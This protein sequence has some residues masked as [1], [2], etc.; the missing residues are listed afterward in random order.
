MYVKLHDEMIKI[1]YNKR[2]DI[3]KK[4]ECMALFDR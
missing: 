2:A 1:W 4:K 3:R